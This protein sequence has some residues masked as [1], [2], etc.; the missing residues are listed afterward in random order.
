MA[1][2][3][4]SD[5]A[6]QLS[7]NSDPYHDPVARVHWD[8]L[9]ADQYWLPPEAVSLYGVPE[10]MSLPE[11]PRRRLSQYE[12]L[13]F[14]DAG[15]W[16]EGIFMERIARAARDAVNDRPTLKYRLNELREEAG[17][18][19]MFLEL[20]ERS[21][22]SLPR[23]LCHRPRLAT[24][25][26]RYAPLESLAFWLATVLGEEIPDR[27]NR[28][29]RRHGEAVCSTVLEMCTAHIVDEAR[30]IA[31]ARE[32]VEQ[33][34]LRTNKLTRAALTP[35]VQYLTRQFVAS[36]YYPSPVLYE[37]AGL[38]PGERW[39]SQARTS[40][41]RREFVQQCIQPTLEVFRRR[42]FGLEWHP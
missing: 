3:S 19:L 33:R 24:W 5:L 6:R 9:S 42:G 12:Y 8:Q 37:L 39:A 11:E 28:Y 7:R 31:Y 17:H 25:F 14:V 10:F 32:V 36:F 26:G 30:H 41:H 22:L 21:G 2:Y 16:L 13:N 18:S 15:L 27:L 34:L 23:R 20:M 40:G 4:P 29:V 38:Y 35:V 1:D